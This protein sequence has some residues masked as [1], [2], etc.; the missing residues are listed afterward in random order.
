MKDKKNISK[1]AGKG[2]VGLLILMLV[3]TIVSR[4]T[5]SLCIPR[6]TADEIEQK[7]IVKRMEGD[8]KTSIRTGGYG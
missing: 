3:F 6:V 4:G 7:S 5:S 2:F 1:I 8:G